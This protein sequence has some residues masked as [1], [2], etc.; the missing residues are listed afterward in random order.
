MLAH[1]TPLRT[2]QI[3]TNEAKAERLP[4]QQRRTD[5]GKWDWR[6][7]NAA[8]RATS[9][10]DVDDAQ[11][12]C[13]VMGDDDDG[14]NGSARMRAACAMTGRS[15]AGDDGGGRLGAMINE[16]QG[17]IDNANDSKP[18]TAGDGRWWV[19]D[20]LNKKKYNSGNAHG[21]SASAQML[22]AHARAGA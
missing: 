9:E 20:K 22:P 11:A 21:K 18:T 6:M 15:W 13:Q 19:G 5:A 3:S 2:T 16:G 14:M 7:A 10:R 17:Q 12:G 4:G 8:I 1:A